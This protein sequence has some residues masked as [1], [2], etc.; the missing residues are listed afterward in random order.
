MA[1]NTTQYMQCRKLPLLKVN[2]KFHCQVG[3]KMPNWHTII[4]TASGLLD[5]SCIHSP[6]V[7][8][9]GGVSECVF[10]LGYQFVLLC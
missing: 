5:L 6:Y 1:R 9:P 3:L 8:A 10:L 7:D 4:F 2:A